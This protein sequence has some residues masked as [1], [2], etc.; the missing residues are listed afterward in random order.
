LCP[1]VASAD[2][3]LEWNATAVSTMLGQTP[4]PNAFQQARFMAITQFAVFEAVNATTGRYE[5]YL[6]TIDAPDGDRR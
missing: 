2:V 6:G 4:A 3:V 5:P 1:A